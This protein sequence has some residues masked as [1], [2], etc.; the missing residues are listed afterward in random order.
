MHDT[1]IDMD[2]TRIYRVIAADA[3]PADLPRLA[4]I[5]REANYQGYI[6]LEYEGAEDPWVAVPVWLKKMKQAFGV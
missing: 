3:S 1:S 4:K 6:A 5:L 2:R